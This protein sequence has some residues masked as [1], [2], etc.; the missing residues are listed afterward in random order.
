MSDGV[1]W[2]NLAQAGLTVSMC[3]YGAQD[4]APPRAALAAGARAASPPAPKPPLVVCSCKSSQ[5]VF[6]KEYEMCDG[7]MEFESRGGSTPFNQQFNFHVPNTSSAGRT[8]RHKSDDYPK[9]VTVFTIGE[10]GS[11]F[12]R[13]PSII[14]LGGRNS[15]RL[16]AMAQCTFRDGWPTNGTMELCAKISEDNGDSW[17]KLMRNITGDC[18]DCNRSC[19]TADCL[20]SG[21][22]AASVWDEK[23]EQAV[24]FFDTRAN[25]G[26]Q[27]GRV[28]F[29]T[30]SDGLTWSKPSF[31]FT[32]W[33]TPDPSYDVSLSAGPGLA[34]QLTSGPH[35]GRILVGAYG[36][37]QDSPCSQPGHTCTGHG[38]TPTYPTTGC[39]GSSAVFYSDDLITFHQSK[40]VDTPTSRLNTFHGF[41]EPNPVVL[42]NGSVRVDL[43]NAGCNLQ[44][45]TPK[46]LKPC[47]N[48]VAMHACPRFTCGEPLPPLNQPV[49]CHVRGSAIS[50]D[51]GSTFTPPL[52][53]AP[54]LWDPN[55]Q[56]SVS[57]E[58]AERSSQ[59]FAKA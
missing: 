9:Q 22:D 27:T 8:N 57:A 32:G 12:F 49:T 47:L 2:S 40:V 4:I 51:G 52:E 33:V 16:L 38:C 17:G 56:A 20:G 34:A 7:A 41:Y 29:V 50:T 6:S 24:V 35:A 5:D 44:C 58:C 30:S 42:P 48:P 36:G 43:R 15:S 14:Q 18:A 13:I 45:C 11:L 21:F 10:E 23:R 55:C 26:N 59:A 19:G 39:Q 53:G 28:M 46:C 25:L 37:W 54:E 31:A 1:D 3:G